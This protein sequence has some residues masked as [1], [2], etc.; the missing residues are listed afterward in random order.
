MARLWW[1][2]ARASRSTPTLSTCA[3]VSTKIHVPPTTLL[4][5]FRFS[6]RESCTVSQPSPAPPR[7]FPTSGFEVLDSSKGVEEETLPTYR[8]EK[9][10]PV[11]I[12]EVLGDR[13]QVVAK[14]GYGVTST[15]WLARDMQ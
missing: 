2:A 6:F 5:P 9:Y 14:I 11:H 1:Y 12:G 7:S 15:V 3:Y 4:F 8:A 10:Y 13:Y